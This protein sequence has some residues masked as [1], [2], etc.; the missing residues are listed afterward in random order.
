[1]W[2]RLCET[3]LAARETSAKMTFHTWAR[4]VDALSCRRSG[5]APASFKPPFQILHPEA[6]VHLALGNQEL[7]LLKDEME[8]DESTVE[9]TTTRR[10]HLPDP[11]PEWSIW[12]EGYSSIRVVQKS[13]GRLEVTSEQHFESAFIIGNGVKRKE[14][15]R[16]E[17]CE[18][19]DTKKTTDEECPLGPAAKRRRS[20]RVLIQRN[21]KV[22]CGSSVRS[23]LVPTLLIPLQAVLNGVANESWSADEVLKLYEKD[24]RSSNDENPSEVGKENCR[25]VRRST[26]FARTTLVAPPVK[27]EKRGRRTTLGLVYGDPRLMT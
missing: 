14:S 12:S 9:E 25:E 21:R 20:E 23:W 5:C 1:M 10:F 8:A 18:K 4:W 6:A 7:V 13:G 16:L 26:Y 24:F 19:A 15:G 27:Q 22:G 17:Q 3:W 2:I 11:L